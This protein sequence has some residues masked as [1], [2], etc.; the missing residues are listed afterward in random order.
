M[1]KTTLNVTGMMCPK[2]EAHMNNAIKEAFKVKSVESS[3]KDNKTV[4]VSKEKLDEKLIE[5][6]VAAAGYKL[7]GIS[8]EVEEKKGFSLF[9]KK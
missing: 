4:I 8:V 7:G 9:G 5:K 6:A 1:F 3:H 2:C